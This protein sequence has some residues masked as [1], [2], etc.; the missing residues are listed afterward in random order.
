[1]ADDPLLRLQPLNRVLSPV[2]NLYP[3]NTPPNLYTSAFQHFTS[4]PW[5]ADL[6]LPPASSPASPS[7]SSS[8]GP[9]IIPFVPQAFN[10][11]SPNHDQF[12][13]STLATQPHAL[14]YMLSFF[15]APLDPTHLH[16][17]AFPIQRTHTLFSL[18]HALS[19]YEGLIH[20]G[21]TAAMVDV[22]TGTINEINI[23]LGKDGLVHQRTS[24]TAELSVKYLRPMPAPGVVC[25][26][27]W[28]ERI[29]GRKTHLG[30]EIKDGDGTVLATASS[31]WVA[32]K[33]SL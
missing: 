11:L 8:S 4:I 14:H 10:P 28:L 9:V 5:C 30:C 3:P 19:G 31:I 12:I 18:G 13:G 6:L 21:V 1:M 32:L 23:A 2:L 15:Q 25:V 24:V 16:D 7:S 27:A 33:P 26:T 22:A 20:G 29:E 17:P